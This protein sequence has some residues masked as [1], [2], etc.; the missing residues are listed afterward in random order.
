[1]VSW[2]GGELAGR[3]G[4]GVV[5]QWLDG[6][7][8][9]RWDSDGEVRATHSLLSVE[10]EHADHQQPN[11][12]AP[13]ESV[14]SVESNEPRRRATPR[15]LVRRRR[16]LVRRG[17]EVAVAA[18]HVGLHHTLVLREGRWANRKVR[19]RVPR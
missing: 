12:W 11:L 2:L 9:G 15:A 1:M 6:R 3:R 8:T 10:L 17:R 19:T 16:E 14:E 18:D 13:V 4:G 5:Q 7:A